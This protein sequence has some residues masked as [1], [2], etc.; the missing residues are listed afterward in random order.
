MQIFL[1]RLLHFPSGHISL[2]VPNLK[3]DFN[4]LTAYS[5]Y[6]IHQK[7]FISAHHF[8]FDVWFWPISALMLKTIP[9]S[10]VW[11]CVLFS[12]FSTFTSHRV[13]KWTCAITHSQQIFGKR[14]HRINFFTECAAYFSKFRTIYR[15]P[16]SP[17]HLEL[18]MDL[19]TATGPRSASASPS[20]K[21]RRNGRLESEEGRQRR[22]FSL[23]DIFVFAGD[24]KFSQH[25]V[26]S[27]DKF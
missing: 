15:R 11:R 8:N 16:F 2:E 18:S 5:S 25:F 10:R 12:D 4:V 1:F 14:C 21:R 22:K 17:T 24:A 27:V 3:F 7:P 20:M 6:H 13:A 26:F 19:A 9:W 23:D